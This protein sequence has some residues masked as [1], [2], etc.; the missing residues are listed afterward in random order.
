MAN[1]QGIVEVSTIESSGSN[2]CAAAP[3]SGLA[4][5][6]LYSVV[7][8]TPTTSLSYPTAPG[9]STSSVSS[10]ANTCVLVGDAT[11]TTLPE[12]IQGADVT[13]SHPVDP[14]SINKSC[15]PNPVV[16]GQPARCT[17]IVNDV[18]SSGRIPP[19]GLVTWST[20]GSGSC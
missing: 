15:V 19:V 9:C 12:N 17:V 16:V 6:I 8:V 20:D 1:S 18:A 11:G 5:T 7:G 10:P 3:C 14:T 2:E 4:F 13:Q